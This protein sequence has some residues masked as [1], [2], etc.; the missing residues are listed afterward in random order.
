[1]NHITNTLLIFS[2]S[3][4]PQLPAASNRRQAVRLRDGTRSVSAFLLTY[5]AI[6]ETGESIHAK[7]PRKS[8][9]LQMLWNNAVLPFLRE[10]KAVTLLPRKEEGGGVEEGEQGAC[11]P[12]LETASFFCLC[13]FSPVVASGARGRSPC[14]DSRTLHGL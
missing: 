14:P 3:E 8:T 11:P 10:T 12:P 4:S 9:V 1:M 6:L 2:G 5:L 13:P 7:T